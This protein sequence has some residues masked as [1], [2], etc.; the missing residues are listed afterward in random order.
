MK[1]T[2]AILADVYTTKIDD[3][4]IPMVIANAQYKAWTVDAFIFWMPKLMAKMKANGA[5]ITTQVRAVFV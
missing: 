1:N 4:E 2:R 3:N 5:N